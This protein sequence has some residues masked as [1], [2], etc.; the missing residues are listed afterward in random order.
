MNHLDLLHKICIDP[1]T[2][3]ELYCLRLYASCFIGF[4]TAVVIY[5][6][7]GNILIWILV[8]IAILIL[9][10]YIWY[11]TCV[12]DTSH[13]DFINRLKATMKLLKSSYT[14][15]YDDEDIKLDNNVTTSSRNNANS[16]V[17]NIIGK[18]NIFDKQYTN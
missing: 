1:F 16:N 10:I 13:R 18:F 6:I 8:L 15:S 11:C 3:S 4:I 2:E 5:K 17:K 9:T 12:S 7:V 14:V